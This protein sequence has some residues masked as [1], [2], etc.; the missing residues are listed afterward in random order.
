MIKTYY[1]PCI[2]FNIIKMGKSKYFKPH[3]ENINKQPL[4]KSAD[5]DVTCKRLTTLYFEGKVF[6][7]YIMY[8]G[9]FLRCLWCVLVAMCSWT[10]ASWFYLINEMLGHLI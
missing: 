5:R 3:L 10:L 8:F 6:R 4:P 2:E 1:N 9:Y 7:H